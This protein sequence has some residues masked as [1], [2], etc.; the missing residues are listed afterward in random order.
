MNTVEFSVVGKHENISLFLMDEKACIEYYQYDNIKISDSIY[1]K[2]LTDQRVFK[3]LVV[4]LL[5]SSYTAPHCKIL[6]EV[7]VLFLLIFFK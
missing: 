5:K 1:S 4:S 3:S 7:R 6:C 2:I